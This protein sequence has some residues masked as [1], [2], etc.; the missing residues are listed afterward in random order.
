MQK[1]SL[2][3]FVVLIFLYAC[4][5][6]S[7]MLLDS[8]GVQTI[9]KKSTPKTPLQIM[10]DAA[11]EQTAPD[12]ELPK[13]QDAYSAMQDTAFYKMVNLQ[14]SV[15]VILRNSLMYSD[16]IWTF[17]KSVAG[18]IPWQI[19]LQ[20]IRNIPAEFYNPSPVELVQRQVMIENAFDVPF[21]KT[22]QRYGLKIS[23]DAIASFLGLTEDVSPK[24]SYTIDFSTRVEVVVYSISSTVVAT[25]FDGVQPPGNYTLTWNGR[26]SDGQLMPPGDYIAEVRIGNEKYLRKRIVV[27]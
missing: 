2:L 21:V 3:F 4:V 10:Q 17:E 8:G 6:K 9:L 12:S 27:R 19:A 23:T 1:S 16:D 26:N 18:G 20:N 25:L 11:N 22:I 5:A 13:S 24:I 15:N 14:L 7:N